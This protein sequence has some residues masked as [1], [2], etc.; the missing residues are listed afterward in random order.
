[1]LKVK[2]QKWSANPKSEIRN[3]KEIRTPKIEESR[4]SH[5][6][7]G[8]LKFQVVRRGLT[9]LAI[10]PFGAFRKDRLGIS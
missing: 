4:A 3:P 8:F 5:Y 2:R 6:R 10:N 7:F 9:R 1:M